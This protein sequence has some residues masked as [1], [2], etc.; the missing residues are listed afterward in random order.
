MSRAKRKT[1]SGDIPQCAKCGLETGKVCDDCGC[2]QCG[3]CQNNTGK[4]LACFVKAN[5]KTDIDIRPFAEIHEE[6][7]IGACHEA[8]AAGCDTF[9]KVKT[10][11]LRAKFI[12][13]GENDTWP[14]QFDRW[15]LKLIRAGNIASSNGKFYLR[16]GTPPS[17]G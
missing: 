14:E 9:S 17:L 2:P 12:P 16:T 10:W 13:I 5:Q 3:P 1:V 11:V 4:C 15:L 8:V 7:M 6:K